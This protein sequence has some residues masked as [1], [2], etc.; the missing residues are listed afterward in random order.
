MIGIGLLGLGT[1][2][3]GIVEILEERKEEIRELLGST[4]EI[5]K[6]LVLNKDKP[7][8]IPI[9]RDLVTTNYEDLISDKE[10][11]IVVEVTGDQDRAYDYV[12]EAL[13]SGRH[14]VSANKALVSKYFEELSQLAAD[15]NLAFLYEA[16]VAGAVPVIKALKDQLR[17]NRIGEVGGI[18]NGTCNF[19][20]TKMEEEEL[21]YG[22]ALKEAQELGYAELDPRADVGG[23]DS[24][25]KL[26][27]LASLALQT[28]VLEETIILEGIE[29][30]CKLDMEMAN[31]LDRRIKLIA[32]ARLVEEGFQ[33]LVMPSL[34]KKDKQLAGVRGAFNMVEF[35]GDKVGCLSFYGL[36]AGGQPTAN[37]VL[38]DL[39]DIVMDN[40]SSANPLVQVALENAG[41][42]ISDRFYVRINK[43]K[44][45]LDQALEAIVEEVII[46]GPQLVFIT[47]VLQ[48][49]EIYHV[50][51]G[52]SIS[53]EDYFIAR[54]ED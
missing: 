42:K 21:D 54:L 27:I 39:L 24:L 35:R 14:V 53:R 9:D 20:L 23:L 5:R 17:L 38:N 28:Q 48:L 3:T 10:I 37:A 45:G 33:A 49:D 19:I 8:R 51:E 32:R 13:E 34:L 12:K 25:R 52:Q 15:K 36:G 29:K 43:S 11:Q 41:G 7:R 4:I 2:G 50:L 47:K 26:R 31:K 46:S 30:I 6:I 1:V 22:Q 18:V 44:G 16:S 40:F